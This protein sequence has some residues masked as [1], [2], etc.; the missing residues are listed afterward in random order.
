M[1]ATPCSRPAHRLTTPCA[2]TVVLALLA[3]PAL[4]APAAPARD[5]AIAGPCTR[6]E[7]APPVQVSVGKS[8]VIRPASAIS[9]IVLGHPEGSRAGTPREGSVKAEGEH[10]SSGAAASTALA[11]RDRLRPGVADIDVVLLGSTELFV[12]GKSLGSTHVVLQESS[13]RC[14][15]VDV[16]VSLDTIGL[17]ALLERM[18]PQEKDLRVSAAYDSI[19]LA[20][21]VSDSTALTTVLELA[22]AYVRSAGATGVSAPGMVSGMVGGINP[23]IIN[24]L[25]TGAP[26]QVM[27]EVK[28]A[29]VSKAMLDQFG[30]D[31]SRAYASADGSTIRFLSGLLGGGAITAGQISGAGP[32]GAPLSSVGTVVGGSIPSS[33]AT[34]GNVTQTLTTINGQVVPVYTTSYGTVPARGVTNL[35][36]NAQKT[37]GVV[38]VLA[39]P[40]VMAISGQKGSFL[41]GGKIFI[42]VAVDNGSS[43][44][45]VTLEE[46]EFGVSVNFLPTVLG[47]GRINLEVASEVSEL[48]AQGIAVTAL[49]LNGSTILPTFTSRRAKTTVQLA[50]GQSFA[51]G[52]LIKNN[53]T[54]NV[55]AFPVLGEIPV[56][57]A[58]F[59]STEFQTDKSELVFVITPRLVKPLAPGYALPTDRYVPP[60]RTDL[61]LFGRAEGR[62]A[63]VSDT[64]PAEPPQAPAAGFQVK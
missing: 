28:V 27:L 57:G 64:A 40:T 30:I 11:E 24:L 38:K 46:K 62:A 50:D 23:R 8:T 14:T 22:N 59:R 9:R 63:P 51:I 13:G 15:A 6:V 5:N 48:N 19:V 31:F 49:G 36:V 45:T 37:D 44:R 58:L 25:S 1:N 53:A 4:A 34:A 61:H 20:G 54:T 2:T 26:Q 33:I 52:G 10:G 39:E 60:S 56:L 35:G 29:E 43:G 41:A 17:Q 47:G 7:I 55:R 12:L 16:V 21:T 42:P 18:L 32:S 3:G